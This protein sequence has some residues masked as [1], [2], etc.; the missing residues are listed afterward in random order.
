LATTQQ[1]TKALRVVKSNLDKT[2]EPLGF[3]IT[4]AGI[5]WTEPPIFE[6]SQSA[7]HAAASFLLTILQKGPRLKTEID[8]EAGAAEISDA[9]VTRAKKSLGIRS[10]KQRGTSGRWVWSLPDRKVDHE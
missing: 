7:T 3:T 5:K 2:P 4:E 8:A 6:E 10:T 1:G 9:A